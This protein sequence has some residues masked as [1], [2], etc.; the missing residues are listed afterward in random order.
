M[1]GVLNLGLVL[2]G[3]GYPKGYTFEQL[4]LPAAV[5][6]GLVGLYQLGGSESASL[7]NNVAGG[8]SLLS[9]GAPEVAGGEARLSVATGYY[10]T[11]LPETE[12]FSILAVARPGGGNEA[13]QIA[14][15]GS[16]SPAGTSLRIDMTATRLGT[17]DGTATLRQRVTN[18]STPNA[19][20][21][22]LVAG[23]GDTIGLSLYLGQRG[24]TVTGGTAYTGRTVLPRTWRIGASYD[25][26]VVSQA[27]I[28]AA[29][30]WNRRLTDAEMA[31][32]FIA[33][34]AHFA[35]SGV[36]TL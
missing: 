14:T 25:T 11:Q 28:A 33:I 6:G 36:T 18:L 1:T 32:A 35:A 5:L 26:G 4:A 2:P 8:P 19:D 23:T 3:A 17:I 31:A 12:A 29:A 9:V 20:E 27:R 10:D 30:I 21:L 16:G 22:Y 24:A 15:Y 34:R 7:L 13:M